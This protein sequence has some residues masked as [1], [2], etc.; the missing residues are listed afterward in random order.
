MKTIILTAIAL[1]LMN[2]A[3]AFACED[4]PLDYAN[5]YNQQG[6]LVYSQVI[7]PSWHVNEFGVPYLLIETREGKF[8]EIYGNPIVEKID[9]P[10]ERDPETG[11]LY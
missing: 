1:F 7:N 6:K 9:A 3:S 10:K 2:V 4:L 11:L 5:I 8:F